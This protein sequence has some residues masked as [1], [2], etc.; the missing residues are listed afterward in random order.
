MSVNQNEVIKN[1][2][3][4][5]SIR[6]YKDETVDKEI[7]KQIIQAGRYA[8]SAKN[9]QPWKFIVI[10]KKD[11]IQELSSQ[12]KT[13]LKK[14]LKKRIIKKLFHKELR[15]RETLDFLAVTAFSKED[16]IFYN[17]PALVLI[18][19][20]DKLF[21]DES[22]AC[23]AE[24]MMLAAHSLGVGSCWIGFASA[25]GL[26]KQTM[27]KIGVPEKHHISAAIVFGYP[28]KKTKNPPMRKV[29]SDIIKWIE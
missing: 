22:C 28:K 23:C 11:L 24:N 6:N 1:I 14:L 8:P 10:T 17:A 26:N 4:R 20:E 25:L 29:Y 19:T 18:L 13:E 7:L 16:V 15:E 12:I 9:R 3:E 27:E 5:R 2:M 21:Y